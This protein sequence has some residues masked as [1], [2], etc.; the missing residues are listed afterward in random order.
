MWEYRI[1]AEEGEDIRRELFKRL[2]QRNWYLLSSKSYELSL[3]DIFL[4]LTMGEEISKSD[5]E[6]L[7]KSKGGNN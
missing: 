3:E 6:K 4:K 7:N 5:R 2:A 1:E